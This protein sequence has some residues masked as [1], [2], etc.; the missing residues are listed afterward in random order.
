MNLWSHL[1]HRGRRVAPLGLAALIAVSPAL[2]QRDGGARP[3]QPP[4]SSPDVPT[5]LDLQTV[6]RYALENNF[7]IRQARERIREQEGLIVEIKAQVLPNASVNSL[8]TYTDRELSSDSAAPDAGTRETEYWSIALQVRQVLY[9]GGGVRNALDAQQLAREAAL[10]ELQSVIDTALLDVRTRYYN[11]LFAAEQ[12]KVE[13]ENVRLLE[14]QLQTAKNR[15]EAGSSSNFEVLRAEVAVA[16]AR[17]N[18]IRARNGF[19]IAIDELRQAMGY[20]N[21]D[22]VNTHR[23]PTFLGELEYTP[24]SYD[25][26]D[27]IQQARANR[28]ELKRLAKIELAQEAGV[29]VAK[30]GYR[31]DL[32]IVGGY[33]FRKNNFSNRFKESLDGWTIGLQS[34]WAIFDGRATAGRV[35]Q[36]RSRLNQAR[37][38]SEEAS[39]AVE[40]EVRRA[41]SS[42]LEAAELAEAATKVVAQAEEALRLADSRYAAGTA[43]QLD[44]LEARVALTESRNNQLFANYSHTVAVAALRKAMG[45]ADPFIVQP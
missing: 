28:P 21:H 5:Q 18:L 23:T 39:L 30:A 27:A 31:P 36:A 33:E 41:H 38:L 35:A 7:A 20:L 25:L 16:N 29:N 34:N 40:V 2:A 37:L 15:F 4:P 14:E 3:S 32:A 17:P 42:L 8:Y 45:T 10:L 9:A 26:H 13:E 19:R 44:V 1:L 43:T 12:T 11:V 24:V 6:I 22:P